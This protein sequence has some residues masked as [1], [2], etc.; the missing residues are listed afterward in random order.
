ML[1]F[2]R[3]EMSCDALL[4]LIDHLPSDSPFTAAV[5]EDEEYAEM[6]V[7]LPDENPAP[8]LTEF[9]PEVRALAM[10][11]DKLSYLISV[12]YQRSSQR[13]P[14]MEPYPRPVTAIDRI[15]RRRKIQQHESLK[16]RLL[17]GR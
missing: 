15:R 17:P 8:R 1:D 13:P 10:I 14:R 4:D 2:F 7:D 12:Q 11:V 6:V 5:A 3:G 16:A 9:G